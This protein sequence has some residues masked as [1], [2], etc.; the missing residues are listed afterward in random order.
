MF[1]KSPHDKDMNRML[2]MGQVGME[3]VAPIVVGLL[4]D[5]YLHWAPWGV[6]TGT[7]L[8]L[9]M[10]LAHLVYLVNQ[11]S[12]DDPPRREPK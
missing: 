2:A 12:G 6:V 8:G 7:I 3:M 1:P 5:N 4:L 9:C 10:G 11:S